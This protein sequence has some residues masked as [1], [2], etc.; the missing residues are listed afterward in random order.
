[1]LD[2]EV[3]VFVVLVAEAALVRAAATDDAAVLV[4][5][6]AF[7]A[8]VDGFPVVV[9]AAAGPLD[10]VGAFASG[11][12]AAVVVLLLP[13]RVAALLVA[14]LSLDTAAEADGLADAVAS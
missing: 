14:V 10:E 11:L 2:A 8:S 12:R 3:A 5:G 7:A 6:A 1:M 9:R 13:T 4:A